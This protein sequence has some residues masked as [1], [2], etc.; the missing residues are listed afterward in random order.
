VTAYVLRLKASGWYLDVRAKAVVHYTPEAEHARQ[1]ASMTSAAVA[2][3]ILDLTP[4]EY[5]V[6]QVEVRA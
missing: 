4:D 6:V 2:A 5:E 1:F 3:D